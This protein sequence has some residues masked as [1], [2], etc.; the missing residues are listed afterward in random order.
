MNGGT[1]K[2]SKSWM[3]ILALNLMV[4]M[5]S[6]ILENPQIIWEMSHENILETWV[7]QEW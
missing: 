7:T 6:P 1:P 4:K 2:S 5:G 3:S